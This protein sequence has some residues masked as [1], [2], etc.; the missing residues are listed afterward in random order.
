MELILVD[1]G[2]IDGSVAKMKKFAMRELKFGSLTT[3]FWTDPS[4]SA[5]LEEAS[6]EIIANRWRFTE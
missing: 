5:G 2:S 1:D 6:G 3:K 4:M